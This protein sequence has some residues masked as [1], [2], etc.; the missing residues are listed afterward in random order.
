M[1]RWIM[2]H[3][4]LALALQYTDIWNFGIY[5]EIIQI[6]AQLGNTHTVIFMLGL[7]N[8]QMI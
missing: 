2:I 3:I 4:S 7:I 1:W 6:E 8:I 5:I